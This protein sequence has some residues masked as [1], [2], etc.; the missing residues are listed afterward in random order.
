MG[1]NR[2]SMLQRHRLYYRI[3]QLVSPL[4]NLVLF[5]NHLL[6]L[7]FSETRNYSSARMGRFTST[8]GGPIPFPH[9]RRR[10]TLSART[11]P[12]S[13]PPSTTRSWGRGLVRLESVRNL[14]FHFK[15]RIIGHCKT[16]GIRTRGEDLVSVAIYVV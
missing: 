12:T 3:P 14:W 8:T 9:R 2:C 1:E 10:G 6:S 4:Q 5:F 15:H 7:F 13:A 11:A 16:E